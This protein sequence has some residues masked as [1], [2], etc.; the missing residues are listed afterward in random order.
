[1]GREQH[2][3]PKSAD[4]KRVTGQEEVIK[5]DFSKLLMFDLDGSFIFDG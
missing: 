2:L 5:M 1:M 3:I 4:T